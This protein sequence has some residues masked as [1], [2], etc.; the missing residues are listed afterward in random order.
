MEDGDN[1]SPQDKSTTG[2]ENELPDLQKNDEKIR[3]LLVLCTVT[4][5]PLAYVV[6]II[7]KDNAVLLGNTIIGVIA[8]LVFRYYFKRK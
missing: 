7:T 6:Y 2:H 3:W 4:Y 5:I 8:T 1:I